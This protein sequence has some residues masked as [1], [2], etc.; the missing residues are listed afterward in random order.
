MRRIKD[1]VQQSSSG[2]NLLITS[3][4]LMKHFSSN[5]VFTYEKKGLTSIA[6]L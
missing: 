2:F 5:Q 4:T 6:T 3:Y 1:F